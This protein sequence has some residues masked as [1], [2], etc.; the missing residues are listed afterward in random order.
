MH[1]HQW[2][3]GKSISAFLRANLLQDICVINDPLARPD[4]QSRPVVI[5]INF[6]LKFV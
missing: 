6:H 2:R 3:I 1:E 4:P 5:T